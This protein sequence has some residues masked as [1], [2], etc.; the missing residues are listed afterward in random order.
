M[1]VP[2]VA[3]SVCGFGAIF[4]NSETSGRKV[5][6]ERV[7]DGVMGDPIMLGPCFLCEYDLYGR[8]MSSV[9]LLML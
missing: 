1:D 5:A 3:P 2:K 4:D 7:R 6:P 8:F 9:G